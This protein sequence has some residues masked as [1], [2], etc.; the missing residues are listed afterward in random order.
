MRPLLMMMD[1][2]YRPTARAHARALYSIYHVLIQIFIISFLWIIKLVLSKT[3]VTPNYRHFLKAGMGLN[4]G[5]RT[6]HP[7]KRQYLER[8]MFKNRLQGI[9]YVGLICEALRSLNGS[10][11]AVL[12]C[13]QGSL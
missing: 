4:C 11:R 2:S 6:N 10:G 9:R 7:F 5:A 8:N 3:E 12:C 13:Q 1:S